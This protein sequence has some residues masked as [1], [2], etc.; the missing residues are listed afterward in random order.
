MEV[1][2]GH[3]R[4]PPVAHDDV[5]LLASGQTIERFLGV[6]NSNHVV[7][8]REHPPD[9]PTDHWMDERIGETR[10]GLTRE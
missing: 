7:L 10:S 4:H 8:R 1:H 5:E 2:P 9:G 6:R 3:V